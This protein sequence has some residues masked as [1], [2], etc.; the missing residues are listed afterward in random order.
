MMLDYTLEELAGMLGV[1]QPASENAGIRFHAVS[2]DSRTIRPGEIFFALSGE[3]FD[4]NRFV[5]DAFAKGAVAAV[6]RNPAPGGVC[7]LTDDPCKA[8]QRLAAYHRSRS[9][10]VVIAVTGSC[11][12]TT[13]KN[14]LREIL[15][16]LGPVAATQGNLNNEIGCPLSLLQIGPD[17]RYAVIEMG[18]NHPGEIRRLCELAAPDEAIV[19]MV[20]PAHLEGFGSIEAVARAKEEIREGLR[21][22][23]VFYA[24]ADDPSC[25][26]M[27]E[28]HTGPVVRFGSAPRADV[29]L[30]AAERLPDGRLRAVIEPVGE[31]LLHLPVRAQLTSVLACAAVGLRHAVPRLKERLEAACIRADRARLHWIGPLIV[32]DDTY[33]ANPASMRA[34]LEALTELRGAGGAAAALGSMFELGPAAPALHREIGALAVRLGVER[35][36]T[37]GPNAGDYVAGAREAGMTRVMACAD[38]EAIA[39]A[40]IDDAK[41]GDVLLVKGSRGTRMELLIAR[42]VE[43]WGETEPEL[44]PPPKRNGDR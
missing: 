8:L 31:L 38:H 42:L 13:T 1:E 18:A 28:R 5:A 11:G 21:P 32:L 29:R 17:S 30:T 26:A 20:A 9:R 27:A 22:G 7:L 15:E 4:G 19:T 34:A 2:T 12:K 16:G 35:M 43:H 40:V 24:N 33:N 39:R 14:M 36:Y 37:L 10:A 25:A 23:G 6:C 44:I 41:C 3:R